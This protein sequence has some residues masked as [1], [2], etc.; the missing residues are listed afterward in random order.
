MVYSCFNLTAHSTAFAFLRKAHFSP[1]Y[2]HTDL[3]PSP[4]LCVLVSWVSAVQDLHVSPGW[5][6]MVVSQ[7][8]SFQGS[9]RFWRFSFTLSSC[10]FLPL[11]LWG[12]A[13]PACSQR[14]WAAQETR[15]KKSPSFQSGIISRFVSHKNILIVSFCSQF[16]TAFLLL[17]INK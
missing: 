13:Y 14:S 11:A 5:E 15:R 3:S 1:K 2:T 9:W 8:V 7:L 4:R 12:I 10:P 16:S 17:Q 6:R